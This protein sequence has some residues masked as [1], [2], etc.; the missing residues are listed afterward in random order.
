MD[1]ELGSEE[2][3]VSGQLRVT[4]PL[5]TVIKVDKVAAGSAPGGQSGN[6]SGGLDVSHQR[7]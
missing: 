6:Q 2:E 3:G 7:L 1:W 4:P 5:L